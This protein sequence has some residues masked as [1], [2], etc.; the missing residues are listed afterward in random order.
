MVYLIKEMIG[1][2]GEVVWDRSKPD[3]KPKRML[4]VSKAEREFGFKAET[5]FEVG[6]KKTICWY[7]E[8]M[9]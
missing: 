3:G 6:L 4:D 7:R 8:N 9:L 5:L 1:Y 2:G